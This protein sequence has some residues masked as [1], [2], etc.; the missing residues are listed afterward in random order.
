[1]TDC[2]E[3]NHRL[4]SSASRAILLA[5]PRPGHV[6]LQ[7]VAIG[8]N[9]SVSRPWRGD[10]GALAYSAD[11]RRPHAD[12][13]SMISEAPRFDTLFVESGATVDSFQYLFGLILCARQRH[14]GIWVFGRGADRKLAVRFRGDETPEEMDA[15]SDVG[16]RL[17]D[18]IGHAL[19]SVSD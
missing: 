18:D 15:V 11:E 12:A 14:P 3:C 10:S 6:V 4:R 19:A 16:Q 8:D 17:S 1:M 7:L 9:G 5:F 13:Q 2:V